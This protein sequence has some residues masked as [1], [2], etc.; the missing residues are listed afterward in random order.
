MPV[1]QSR[2]P[3]SRLQVALGVLAFAFGS[4]TVVAADAA[5]LPAD[6]IA[7]LR[8]YKA[9]GGDIAA[10]LRKTA[11]SMAAT[12]LT[13]DTKASIDRGAPLEQTLGP[14]MPKQ[15]D[16]KGGSLPMIVYHKE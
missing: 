15:L 1:S 4:A 8:D 7:A 16:N 3:R 5:P 13:L 2:V 9:D 11:P 10:L 14:D 6:T 12:W